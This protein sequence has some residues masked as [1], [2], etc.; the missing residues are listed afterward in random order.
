MSRVLRENQI[1]WGSTGNISARVDANSFLISAGGSWVSE[2]QPD[3]M[4]LCYTD[5]SG[6]EGP[7]PSVE[8]HMHNGVYKQRPEVNYVA[9]LSPHYSTLLACTDMMPNQTATVEIMVYLGRVGR[10]PFMFPGSRPLADAVAEMA[11]DHDSIILA[12]HGTVAMHAT[13]RGLMM[14]VIS[15]E[16]SCRVMYNAAAAGWKLNNVDADTIKELLLIAKV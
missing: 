16:V 3:E 8:W 15:F 1:A 14:R 5:E 12:N 7:R 4:T 13:L 6:Y 2:V 9:H 10:I 11:A